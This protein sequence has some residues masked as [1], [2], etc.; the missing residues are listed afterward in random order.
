MQSRL[1]EIGRDY[2]EIC[3]WWRARDWPYVPLKKLPPAGVVI[4]DSG[5]KY[6]AGWVYYA[7]PGMTWMEWVVSNP[8]SPLMQ[9][10]E[11][12]DKLVKECKAISKNMGATDILTIT[13]NRNLIKLYECNGIIASDDGMTL[14][15]G[16]L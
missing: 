10:K 2:P 6:C 11:A 4:E 3:E 8:R 13:G 15:K 16:T 7:L 14:L 1:F 9:R 5:V 12:L